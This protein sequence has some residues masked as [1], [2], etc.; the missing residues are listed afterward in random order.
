MI[1][2]MLMRLPLVVVACSVI[3]LLQVAWRSP[4][5]ADIAPRDA[6]TAPGQPCNTAGPTFDQPGICTATTCTRSVPTPMTYACNLCQV[7]SSGTGGAAGGSGGADGGGG[8]GGGA[9]AAATGGSAGGGV[10]GESGHPST[11][12]GGGC[13][14]A[15]T[16]VARASEQDGVTIGWSIGSSLGLIMLMTVGSRS[17]RRTSRRRR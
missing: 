5:R 11:K 15:G 10:A 14:I 4:A 2:A 16:T 8:G 7:A 1:V 12:S 17:R 9:P 3:G 6:C 13:A